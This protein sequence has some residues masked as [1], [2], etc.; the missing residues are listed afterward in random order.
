VIDRDPWASSRLSEPIPPPPAAVPP[1]LF[2]YKL[3][4]GL[5]AVMY[6]MLGIGSVAALAFA[7]SIA[8]AEMSADEWRLMSVFMIVISMPLATAYALPLFLRPS[9]GAWVF[10]IVLMALLMSSCC[11]WPACIPL[12]IY[13]VKPETR[14]YFGA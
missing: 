2:W 6:V 14:A 5:T 11:Y 9:K 10:G 8:D 13:W 12:I 7:D 1:V 4:M 3:T